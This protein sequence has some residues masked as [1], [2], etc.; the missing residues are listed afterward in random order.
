MTDPHFH[1][2]PPA[3]TTPLPKTP[4]L[5]PVPA[6]VVQLVEAY[7]GFAAEVRSLGPVGASFAGRYKVEP[8]AAPSQFLKVFDQRIVELQRHSDRVAAFLADADV[9]VVLPLPGE[10]RP[11]APGHWG[12]LF[13]Y[14]DA[15]F[16]SGDEH[17]LRQLGSVLGRVHLR[18][19]QFDADEIKRAGDEM[20]RRL[21]AVARAVSPDWL[22]AEFAPAVR[23]AVTVYGETP[24][25]IHDG[26]QMIHGDCNYTNVLFDR[27]TSDLFLIDFEESRAAWLNPLFDVA[28]V[29]ERF[30]LVP[31]A[32]DPLRLGTAFLESYA[33][34]GAQL[35]AAV[36][37][38]RIL[39]ESNSR[40]L[41]IMCD[42][43]REGLALP[44]AEWRKFIELTAL[45]S[46]QAPLLTALSRVAA[47]L[48]Q[49]GR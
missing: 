35:P 21:I 47:E 48:T 7:C 29:I 27:G 14:I 33:G 36:D 18:L 46:R 17:E 43:A 16:S 24:L 34:A 6:A 28:K 39:I 22:P 11:F 5:E 25:A 12:E 4:G 37:L 19:R 31:A 3:F 20:H 40:A 15:R 9:P 13:P 26:A 23:D 2:G 38:R 49:G 30:V 8:E 44:A 42:K 1:T 10:P 45:A 32:S 41:L